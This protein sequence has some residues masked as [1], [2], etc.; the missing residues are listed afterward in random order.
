M[1]Y[2]AQF[3]DINNKQYTVYIT[4][5]NNYT[6]GDELTLSSTPFTINYEGGESTIYKP[7]KYSSATCRIMTNKIYYDIYSA[8]NQAT[9]I[10]LIDEDKKQTIWCGYATPNAYTQPYSPID[11]ELEIECVDGLSTLK[12][13]KYTTINDSC[14]IHS[15]FSIIKHC[16][17]HTNTIDRIH[18]TTAIEKK[19]ETSFT[20]L[21]EFFITEKNF[22]DEDDEPMMMS[23]VVEEIMRYLNLTLYT[24]GNDAY[25]I[26]YDAIV[27]NDFVEKYDCILI[28]NG[29]YLTSS[30]VATKEIT[31]GDFMASDASIDILPCYNKV[32]V[33]A[34]KYTVDE[35]TFDIFGGDTLENISCSNR[36]DFITDNAYTGDDDEYHNEKEN[37]YLYYRLLK[38]KNVE[39]KYYKKVDGKWEMT[40]EYPT[41]YAGLREYAGCSLYQWATSNEPQ[42]KMKYVRTQPMSEIKWNNTILFHTHKMVQST[43]FSAEKIEGF[44]IKPFENPIVSNNNTYLNIN[45]TTV[46]RTIQRYHT[47]DSYKGKWCPENTLPY[48]QFFIRNIKTGAFV[49]WGGSGNETQKTA[50]WVIVDDGWILNYRYLEFALDFPKWAKMPLMGL[51]YDNMLDSKLNVFSNVDYTMNFGNIGGLVVKLPPATDLS[52]IEII[53]CLPTLPNYK[54]DWEEHYTSP[55]MD[56]CLMEDL[57]FK[58]VFPSEKNKMTLTEDEDIEENTKYENIINDAWV[59]ELGEINFKVHTNDGDSCDYSSVYILTND[60][61]RECV[62]TVK[63]LAL[64]QELKM[65]EMLIYRIVNQ[66]QKPHISLDL[67]LKN[68]Y[69]LNDKIIYPTQ[70]QGKNFIIDSMSID[71]ANDTSNIKIIEKV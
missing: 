53:F 24:K 68:N 33:V 71:V 4:T 25:V 26:D 7:I 62:D 60:D 65:E 12:N 40:E 10:Q 21:D 35:N 47:A 64:N 58:L 69:D 23:E 6:Q 28:N 48:I 30:T 66:Y 56:C 29:G 49:R 8:E 17:A 2:N 67:T 37:K 36:D 1:R 70:Q 50:K 51:A 3:K 22:Y 31:S 41:D 42:Y 19:F 15:F 13:I 55:N 5:N 46:W 38:Q 44:K 14:K 32:V 16:L 27:S 54:S 43:S 11:D 63:N 45:C 9:K 20:F 18:I 34:D 52:E 61:G 39:N 57:E 59:E